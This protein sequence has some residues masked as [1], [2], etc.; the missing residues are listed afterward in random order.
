MFFRAAV[1]CIP[2]RKAPE[3]RKDQYMKSSRLSV[4][5][6]TAALLSSAVAFAGETN[7]TT[8]QLY[9]KLSVDGKALN[10]G[11]YTVA[12]EGPGPT[13]QVTISQGKQTVASFPAHLAEQAT[14]NNGGAYGSSTEPDGSH[15][16]T[17][18]YVGGT[19]IALEFNHQEAGQQANSSAAK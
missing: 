17:A 8:I 3:T 4:F 5:L 15:A 2:L 13:V 6:F 1:C 9:E 18:I 12:W 14:R 7:K 16:L 19:R 10:P 11:K